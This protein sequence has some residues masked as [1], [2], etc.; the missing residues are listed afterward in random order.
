M[1]NAPLDWLSEL[2]TALMAKE[3]GEWEGISTS[4]D[5]QLDWEQR[6]LAQT[7]DM[8]IGHRSQVF[9]GNGVCVF[10]LLF[11]RETMADIWLML[12]LE[13]DE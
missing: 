11:G 2:K 6:N 3:E 1:T 10:P 13:Y 5:L 9:I 8:M 12:V 4:W 7:I